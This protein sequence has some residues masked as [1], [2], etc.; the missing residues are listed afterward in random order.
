M[1][2]AKESGTYRAYETPSDD[3]SDTSDGLMETQN[4]LK[5]M[6]RTMRGRGKLS[7]TP[8]LGRLI[9]GARN[10]LTLMSGKTGQG[11]TLVL[12]KIYSHVALYQSVHYAS[13]ELTVADM[14]AR[15]ASFGGLTVGPHSSKYVDIVG[16]AQ[17]KT[18][19][20]KRMRTDTILRSYQL[21]RVQ[22]KNLRH[23]VLD[24]MN[25]ML[26]VAEHP[27]VG[28]WDVMTRDMEY[29]RCL[30]GSRSV[31]IVAVLHS[32]KDGNHDKMPGIDSI[33]GHSRIPQEA[34]QVWIVNREGN[35]SKIH[36]AK[37]RYQSLRYRPVVSIGS[38]VSPVPYFEYEEN[39]EQ[40]D[41]QRDNRHD[42]GFGNDHIEVHGD[43][44][45]E[46]LTL[47]CGLEPLVLASLLERC[48]VTVE[49]TIEEPVFNDLLVAGVKDFIDEACSIAHAETASSSTQ[50]AQMSDDDPGSRVQTGR[51]PLLNRHS[52]P[53]PWTDC[54]SLKGTIRRATRHSDGHQLYGTEWI[55][56]SND[57]KILAANI[58]TDLLS[59]RLVS[60]TEVGN[61][62]DSGSN[63]KHLFEGESKQPL[64]PDTEMFT[65]TDFEPLELNAQSSPKI[66]ASSSFE[67]HEQS[68]WPQENALDE[69][70]AGD[71]Q[72][73]EAHEVLQE[74]V[75]VA[76]DRDINT[77]I[78]ITQQGMIEYGVPPRFHR[79]S[80]PVGFWKPVLWLLTEDQKRNNEEL[81]FRFM[82]GETNDGEPVSGEV[83]TDDDREAMVS[84]M[85]AGE[86]MVPESDAEESMEAE[87]DAKEPMVAE[88]DAGESMAGE[89]N[90]N[91][92][93]DFLSDETITDNNGAPRSD[94]LDDGQPVRAEIGTPDHAI[95]VLDGNLWNDYAFPLLIG[96]ADFTP[97]G[98][99]PHWRRQTMLDH[100][101]HSGMRNSSVADEIELVAAFS[102]MQGGHLAV[103][104]AN[105]QSSAHRYG[106]DMLVK[107]LSSVSDFDGMDSNSVSYSDGMAARYLAARHL[108]AGN[109][110]LESS[111]IN[112]EDEGESVPNAHHQHTSSDE[113]EKE[114]SRGH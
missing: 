76:S 94:E 85:D 12:Q 89:A 101:E 50:S 53:I 6:C 20:L 97:V 23:I 52:E 32:K 104:D 16:Y 96:E 51:L 15:M 43:S 4:L 88:M 71:K 3:K 107:D 30:T 68:V 64:L 74:R 61:T 44:Q 36:V 10:T 63:R 95:H 48:R 103:D 58:D 21:A 110:T 109:R 59:E 87:K 47:R 86:S 46:I 102:G 72:T 5:P 28:I 49:S 108:S 84:E 62:M 13:F 111:S 8:D 113:D 38:Q 100:Q 55:T 75:D 82:F 79:T 91:D 14:H 106:D 26:S 29:L 67:I 56:V 35:I 54:G 66:R 77:K 99:I 34:D 92:D 17:S 90:V 9:H 7:G 83:D 39:E 81:V 65:E 60:E 57:D 24:N 11:K 31:S 112:H 98:R 19:Q 69:S 78:S 18:D 37:E 40:K 70:Q 25:Y 45:P 93:G 42:Q 41:D 73:S 1:G 80:W 27:G 105:A 22:H 114:E 33:G 2:T